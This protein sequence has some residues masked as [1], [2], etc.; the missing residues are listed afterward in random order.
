M[1]KTGFG[2]VSRGISLHE[3]VVDDEICPS[4]RLV[5]LGEGMAGKTSLVMRYC[6]NH[7]DQSVMCTIGVDYRSKLINVDGQK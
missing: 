3:S 1:E 7:F 5:M 6:D 4:I 2:S